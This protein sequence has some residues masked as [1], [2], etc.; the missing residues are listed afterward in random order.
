MSRC[1][2]CGST[3]RVEYCQSADADLCLSCFSDEG[4]IGTAER[5]TPAVHA[6]G[7]APYSREGVAAALEPARVDLLDVIEQGIPEREFVPGAPGLP[8]PNRVLAAAP[9]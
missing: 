8:A 2:Q 5:D 9:A 7:N 4:S 1:G 3:E 6:N